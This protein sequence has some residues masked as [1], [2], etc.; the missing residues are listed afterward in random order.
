MIIETPQH[1]QGR[2]LTLQEAAGLTDENSS[3]VEEDYDSFIDTLMAQLRQTPAMAVLEPSL[4]GNYTVCP[5]FGAGDL[6]KVHLNS[7]TGELK[8]S[9]GNATMSESD[10]YNTVPYGELLP[11]PPQATPSTQRGFYNEEFS[12]LRLDTCK[13][14]S[15]DSRSANLFSLALAGMV[16]VGGSTRSI[17]CCS[18]PSS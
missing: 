10:Y 3:K 2:V 8:G 13:D 12:P 7:R 15:T 1:I 17:V 18:H 14:D 4:G 5:I 16:V 6:S 9:Y 11:L